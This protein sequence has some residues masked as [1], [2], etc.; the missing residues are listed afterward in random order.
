[1]LPGRLGVDEGHLGV[2]VCRSDIPQDPPDDRTEA[3]QPRPAGVVVGDVQL[4]GERVTDALQLEDVLWH[5]EQRDR[6][7]P[8]LRR[9]ERLL[10]VTDAVAWDTGYGCA[11]DRL[12]AE[13]STRDR[14][15]VPARWGSADR[16]RGRRVGWATLRGLLHRFSD[17]AGSRRG[18]GGSG[19]GGVVPAGLATVRMHP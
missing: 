7:E 15:V 16:G 12:A 3:K 18:A 8:D 10:R 2:G 14:S 19:P 5:L 13:R 9:R 17:P 1:Q 6:V 11:G 4:R